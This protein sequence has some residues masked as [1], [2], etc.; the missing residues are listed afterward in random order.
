M[1]IVDFI[2]YTDISVMLQMR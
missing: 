1:V 2:L